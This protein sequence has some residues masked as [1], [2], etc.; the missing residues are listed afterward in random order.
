MINLSGYKI[1]EMIYTGKYSTVYRGIRKEDSLPVVIKFLNQE[2]PSDQCL[3]FFKREFE[4]TKKASGEDSL[5]VYDLVPHNNTFGIVMEDM[6]GIPLSQAIESMQLSLSEKLSIAIKIAECLS[7]IHKKNIIHKDINPSNI[8]WNQETNRVEIIDYGIAVE[9]RREMAHKM[10]LGFFEGSAKYC[11]P[12]QTGRINRPVDSRSDL[13]S[14]GITLYELFTSELPFTGKDDSELFYSQIAQK[15]EPP[16][17]IKKNIPEMVSM[18]IL[19]LLEKDADDRY[20]MASGV[21]KD[22][23]QCLDNMLYNNEV[24]PFEVGKFDISDQLKISDKL[25]GRDEALEVLKIRFN[26]V[27]DGKSALIMI[28][29][30]AGIGK[31]SLIM[32]FSKT[33]SLRKGIFINGKFNP[34]TQHI[35]LQGVLEALHKLMNW[36]LSLPEDQLA[37]WKKN[38]LSAVPQNAAILTEHLPELE[39]IIGEQPPII[40]LNP[41]EAHNRFLIIFNDFISLFGSPSAPL[42]F[43]LDDLQWCDSSTLALIKYMIDKSTSSNILFI[44][45]YRHN[46]LTSDHPLLVTLNSFNN[47]AKNIQTVT[48]HP[49]TI[50]D[51][52][53]LVADTF[54]RAPDEDTLSVANMIYRKTGGTPYYI[55]ELLDSLNHHG[56]FELIENKWVCDINLLKKVNVSDNVIDLLAK[57]IN[58]FSPST[59][60]LLKIASCIGNEFDLKLLAI[61][62]NKKEAEVGAILWPVIKNEIIFPLNQNYKLMHLEDTN[63]SIEILFSFQ[64]IRIQQ[65]IYSQIPEE[66]K[67]SIHL[68]IGK[69]LTLSIQGH[70]EPDLLFNKVNHMNKG[71]FLIKEFSERVALRDLNTEAAHKAIKATAFSMAVTYYSIAES[72]LS[73]NEWSENPKAWNLALFNLGESLFLSGDFEKAKDTCERMYPISDTPLLKAKMHNLKARILEFQGLIPETIEEIRKGLKVL[74]FTFPEDDQE[75]ERRIGEGVVSLQKILF[76]SDDSIEKLASLPIMEDEEKI[77]TMELLYNVVAPA[78]QYRP[79]LFILST[80]MMFDLTQ[81]YG[82]TS[83]SCKCLVDIAITHSPTFGD[84]S[85]GYRLGKTAFLLLNRLNAESMKPAVYFSFTFASYR[86]KHFKEALEYFDLAYSS[87]L[88]TGDI[89]HAAYARAHKMHL[90]MQVGKKLSECKEENEDSIQF[91]NETKAGMP[92]LLSN[93][94]QYIINKYSSENTLDEDDLI[95]SKIEQT[96]NTAFLW[97]FYQYNSMYFYIHNELEK[98]QKWCKLSNRF[99]F[100]SLSDFPGPEHFMLKGLLIIR[101]F[102]SLS[103]EE[104]PEK[105]K[106]LTELLNDLKKTADLCPSN[107]VHKYYFLSAEM[108]ILKNDSQEEV[109]NWFNKAIES[110]R[111]DDFMHIKALIY[112]SMAAYWYHKD[113]EMIARAYYREAHFLFK[114]WGAVKKVALMEAKFPFLKSAFSKALAFSSKI[115]SVKNNEIDMTSIMKAMQTISG[116]IRLEKL[117]RSMMSLILENAGARQGVLLLVNGEDKELYIE[118]EKKSFNDEIEVMQSLPYRKSTNICPEI[119]Q[120]VARSLENMVLGNAWKESVF[121][122]TPHIQEAQ[123]KSI[124]S[125]PILYQNKLI[126]VIYLEHDLAEDVFTEERIQTVKILSSQAAISIVNARLYESLE[127][128]VQERTAQLNQANENL[129]LLSLQDP[130]TALHNRRYIF[131]FVSD[132]SVNFITRKIQLQ[133]KHEM[134]DLSINRKVIGV[135]MIDIDLFKTVNDTYGHLAG[136]KVLVSL[137]RLLKEQIRAD[138]FVA[139]WG[140]EEFIIIL[141]TTNPEYLDI[142]ANKILNIVRERP[143]NINEKTSLHITCSIGYSMMPI[144]E[145]S[146]DLLNLEQAINISD[147]A[148]YLAKENGRNRAVKISVNQKKKLTPECIEYLKKLNKTD[149]INKEF[150][151]V[152]L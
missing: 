31:T 58:D 128:K 35:P 122:N 70:E 18:I 11:S 89:Q 10:N 33:V 25:Y 57:K 38:I 61:I 29:G 63:S 14:L 66:E 113:N 95:A 36:L 60:E 46:D 76:S 112:E 139:R 78:L 98:S 64:D 145:L 12:E 39:K 17:T 129:K 50:T 110:L 6:G 103:E 55:H 142:F 2:Y 26:D 27:A 121:K 19:K 84:F 73:E 5:L 22:L 114:K 67:Q 53:E 37:F 72:L 124:L 151:E 30:N 74:G 79:S 81:K 146:P 77:Q 143:I 9:L 21:K 127:K 119:I 97:R 23:E 141:N 91:L 152:N 87:G 32:E 144:H 44:G 16:H 137:S 99:L 56:F 75:I 42:V 34:E 133:K 80:L 62:C 88:Q 68:K 49:L 116:E 108:A 135:F 138:D 148:M 47:K 20:Q 105:M 118:A 82:A 24:M 85:I 40:E 13:Y 92:L 132:F 83:Y 52:D 104:K 150:I 123:I 28:Q 117:L 149:P 94:I 109:L 102:D 120:F 96:K 134:R 126:G 8:L 65:L 45:A 111:N 71:R 90:Y 69:E 130:L 125:I 93:I 107:F 4:I 100:A 86:N 136:D 3:S 59:I 115:H 41:L 15:P 48:L 147:V 140:G 54:R 43:F 51:I 131:E 106:E 7:L 1:T 101:F